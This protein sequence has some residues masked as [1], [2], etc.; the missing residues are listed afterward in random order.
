VNSRGFTLQPLS[1]PPPPPSGLP[2]LDKLC[3]KLEAEKISLQELCQLYRASSKLPLLEEAVRA[4]EGP[5]APLLA[6]RCARA[7]LCF[8]GKTWR[9]A[10]CS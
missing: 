1:T 5:H 4:H 6:D 9:A 10:H 7:A 3:R 2:D 8:H